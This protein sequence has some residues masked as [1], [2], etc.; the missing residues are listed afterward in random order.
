MIPVMR[1]EALEDLFLIMKEPK[2]EL[3]EA[4][5]LEWEE[6]WLYCTY[7]T[8]HVINRSALNSEEIDFVW[9]KVAES[10]VESLFEDNVADTISTNNSF[11]CK[12]WAL[13]SPY[14]K[15]KKNTKSIKKSK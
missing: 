4:L 6:K 2:E 13:R 15:L 9:H 7:H 1:H 12:V 3:R 8:Q 14:A 5:L 10:C 11:T